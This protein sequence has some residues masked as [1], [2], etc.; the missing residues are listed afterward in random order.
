MNNLVQWIIVAVVVTASAIYLVKRL[1]RNKGNCC[2]KDC[3]AGCRI[4][5]ELVDKCEILKAKREQQD[6]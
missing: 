1:T 5:E 4:T 6:K 2:C 3:P